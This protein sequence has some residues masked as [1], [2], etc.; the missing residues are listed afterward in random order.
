MQACGFGQHQALYL[1]E[2]QSVPCGRWGADVSGLR[3]HSLPIE[4]SLCCCELLQQSF[5][6]AAGGSLYFESP[7]AVQC[8]TSSFL[9]WPGRVHPRGA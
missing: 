4:A 8:P 1:G 6:E 9:A 5:W 2:C 7:N 3:S